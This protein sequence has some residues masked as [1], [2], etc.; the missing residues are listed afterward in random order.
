MTSQAKVELQLAYQ[1]PFV[2]KLKLQIQDSE[3]DVS[4]H[5]LKTLDVLNLPLLHDWILNTVSKT[6]ENTVIEVDLMP[7]DKCGKSK[8]H[9]EKKTDV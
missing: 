5:P 1:V 3:M 8:F 6:L 7:D 9:G 2:K 4:V